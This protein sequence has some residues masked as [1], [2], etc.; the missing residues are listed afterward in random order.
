MLLGMGII[1]T[2]RSRAIQ[3]HGFK[4]DWELITGKYDESEEKG[5]TVILRKGGN[6]LVF[7]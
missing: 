2:I 4:H 6:K 7:L 3:I 1:L 5:E